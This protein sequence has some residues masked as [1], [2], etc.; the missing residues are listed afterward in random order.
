MK[1]ATTYIEQDT[2]SVTCMCVCVVNAGAQRLRLPPLDRSAYA[3]LP[4]NFASMPA[5]MLRPGQMDMWE[6]QTGISSIIR[7][8]GL[9]QF[10]ERQTPGIHRSFADMQMHHA[11]LELDLQASAAAH[12]L[13]HKLRGASK[14]GLLQMDALS[15]GLK[16]IE[17]LEARQKPGSGR[18]QVD[19]LLERGFLVAKFT[20]HTNLQKHL[21]T[22]RDD[23]IMERAFVGDRIREKQLQILTACDIIKSAIKGYACVIPHVMEG[24]LEEMAWKRQLQM[25][26]QVLVWTGYVR[27]L[28]PLFGATKLL[29]EWISHGLTAHMSP[30]ARFCARA[31]LQQIVTRVPYDASG[32]VHPY[33]RHPDDARLSCRAEWAYIRRTQGAR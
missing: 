25:H 28:T 26:A 29:C 9:D 8:R 33:F 24:D 20:A 3:A 6:R 2:S 32:S 15:A 14:Q 21:R 11:D 18:V 4:A 7:R 10:L 19:Y 27:E 5:S 12:N 17:G 23:A 22:D 16:I 31:H 1:K 30:R 13:L